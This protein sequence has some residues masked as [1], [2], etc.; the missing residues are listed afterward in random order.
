MKTTTRAIYFLISVLTVLTLAFAP[1]PTA[2]PVAVTGL[3]P[4]TAAQFSVNAVKSVNEGASTMTRV[5]ASGVF[6][7][8]VVQQ[9]SGSAGYVSTRKNTLTQFGMASSYGS[10]GILAHN[11][12]AGAYFSKLSSGSTI[13]VTFSDGSTQNFT[14][15]SVQSY[16]ALNPTSMYSDFADV[17]DSSTTISS[18]DLFMRTFGQSGALVLQTCISKNGNSSWGRMFVIATA[19]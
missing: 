11:Y 5:A 12:L 7:F 10:Y 18:T 4:V 1:A 19:S 2:A 16:Q 17:N 15:S 13:T 14:V 8:A 9:P 3:A 6:D